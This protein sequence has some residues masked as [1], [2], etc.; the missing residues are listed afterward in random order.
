VPAPPRTHARAPCR[1]FLDNAN[2]VEEGGSGGSEV[3]Y[4]LGGAIW[5][6][7]GAGSLLVEGCVLGGNQLLV[8]GADC[9]A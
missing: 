1:A 7:S 3:V 9:H 8:N 5:F 6:D 2:T 4:G